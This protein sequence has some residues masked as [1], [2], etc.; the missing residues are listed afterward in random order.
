MALV[1]IGSAA[2]L[3]A[4]P[5][6]GQVGGGDDGG[7]GG[8]G[9]DGGQLGPCLAQ[10]TSALVDDFVVADALAGWDLESTDPACL[11][12][13]HTDDVFVE[14]TSQAGKCFMRTESGYRLDEVWLMI[15]NDQIGTGDPET[16]FRIWLSE[17]R[18]LAIQN[19][20]AEFFLLD[21]TDDD[22]SAVGGAMA[23]AGQQF[24]RFRHVAGEDVFADLSTDR[25]ARRSAGGRHVAATAAT[26]RS[27][28]VPRGGIEPPTRGFSVRCSTC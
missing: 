27:R 21:C 22:C 19:L 24:W 1:L 10:P 2:C 5:S 20:G 25:R 6:A 13:N 17:A 28:R 15:D 16:E 11:L 18:F 4:P 9:T 14:N 8:G 3:E 7:G 26:R 12:C 23:A